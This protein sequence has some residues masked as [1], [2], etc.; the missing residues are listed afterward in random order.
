MP[1]SH[2]GLELNAPSSV[3]KS[4]GCSLSHPL[5]E[6]DLKAT[7][8]ELVV[9]LCFVGDAHSLPV[10]HTA[11]ADIRVVFGGVTELPRGEENNVVVLTGEWSHSAATLSSLGQELS[12]MM[13][14]EALD[15]D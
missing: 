7:S 2:W 12:Q 9:S 10:G 8:P 15:G 4:V 1:S 5:G 11:E 6:C 14:V 3:A 13:R